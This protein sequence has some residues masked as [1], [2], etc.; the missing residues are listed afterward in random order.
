MLNFRLPTLV[1]WLFPER[2]LEQLDERDSPAFN[3]LYWSTHEYEWERDPLYGLYDTARAPSETIEEGKGDCVDYTRVV[4][5]YVYHRTEQPVKLH[6]LF[7]WSIGEPGHMVVSDG[8]HVYS[9]G[10]IWRDTTIE[11]YCDQSEYSV[12]VTR[13]VRNE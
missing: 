10:E 3:L 4:A 12:F 1:F 6:A 11:E 9:S 13:T 8:D 2:F 7:K 5:S